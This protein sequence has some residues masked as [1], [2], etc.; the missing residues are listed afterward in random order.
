M[1]QSSSKLAKRI[2][3]TIGYSDQFEYALTPHE[4]FQ[5][6][7]LF[8]WDEPVPSK[9]EYQQVLKQLLD[10]KMLTTRS[11]FLGLSSNPLGAT[12]LARLRTHREQYSM[13][14]RAE[15]HELQLFLRRIPF[16]SGV[17]ITGSVA[18]NN[19]TATDDVDFLIITKPHTLWIVRP[20]VIAYSWIK[21]KR[22]SWNREEKNSW[23]FNLWL[24]ESSLRLP[25]S[26]RSFY[27]A[28]D[29]LQAEWLVAEPTVQRKYY[30][31]NLWARRFFPEFFAEARTSG[32]EATKSPRLVRRHELVHAFF[33]YPLSWLNTALYW[34]QRLYMQSHRTSERVGKTAAFFHPRDT[35]KQVFEGWKAS[36]ARN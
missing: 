13:Q 22:R 36:L 10:E 33:L 23:C 12:T 27:T 31:S 25:S 26:K 20:L 8:S 2:L 35:Q 30:T 18:V 19:A 17:L 29:L 34:A 6:L 1:D 24:E 7:Y 14:K 28:Y 16:I 32:L 3:L 5:R 9:K 15:L 11:G 21:K 4:V